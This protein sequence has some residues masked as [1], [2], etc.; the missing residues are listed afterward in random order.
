MTLA[1]FHLQSLKRVNI[2]YKSD[3]LSLNVKLKQQNAFQP[4]ETNK[5]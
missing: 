5:H 1:N 2:K 3:P 4:T